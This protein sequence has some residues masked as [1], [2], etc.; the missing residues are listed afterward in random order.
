MANTDPLT[1]LANRRGLALRAAEIWS[2]ARAD[3]EQVTALFIDLYHFKS[4][5]DLYGHQAGDECLRRIADVLK[6]LAGPSLCVPARYG[7]EEFAVVS[8]DATPRTS[9]PVGS[10]PRSAR[11]AFRTGCRRGPSPNCST[12]PTRRSMSRSRAAAMRFRFSGTTKC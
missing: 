5:N 6:D 8:P 2:R 10:P 4:F 9:S 12:A 1:G 7:G 3:G 11:S